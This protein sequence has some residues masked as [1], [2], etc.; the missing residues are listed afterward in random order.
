MWYPGPPTP[1]ALSAASW[2]LW[3]LSTL[4]WARARWPSPPPA[5]VGAP[6]LVVGNLVVGGTGKTPLVMWLARRAHALGIRPGVVMRGY[7]SRRAQT[8]CLV[9]ARSRHDEVGDEALLV[10]ERTGVPV[11]VHRRRALA[12]R[13]L[14]ER[15]GCDLVIADD[16]LQHRAL[17]R[18]AELAMVDG[19]RGFGNRRLL[20]AGPLREPLDRLDHVDLV[21]ATNRLPRGVTVDGVMRTHLAG[22]VDLNGRPTCWPV[23]PVAAVAGIANPERFFAALRER[24]TITERH[25]FADHYPYR[26]DEGPLGR[27]VTVITTEKDAVRLRALAGRVRAT[28]LVARQQVS[29]A[30]RLAS[31]LDVLLRRLAEAGTGRGARRGQGRQDS[32]EGV[33]GGLQMG[34]PS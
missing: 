3:P 27:R 10:A 19:C 12:A 18:D 11:A 24:V 16:G 22:L 29:F 20:P 26:G 34:C 32:H 5:S 1:A 7:R 21:I 28:V 15:C 4:T 23:G 17:P 13:H 6:V 33:P 14:V 25:V 2:L 31:Q 30:P 8:P 9:T